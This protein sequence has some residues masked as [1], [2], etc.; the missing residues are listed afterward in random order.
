MR[1]SKSGD[2]EELNEEYED[3]AAPEYV[4]LAGEGDAAD[5]MKGDEGSDEDDAAFYGDEPA[6]E[7]KQS[8]DSAQEEQK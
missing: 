6:A 3:D 5:Y 7:E 1:K 2:D 8:A 4:G